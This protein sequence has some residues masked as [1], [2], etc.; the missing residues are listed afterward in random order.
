MPHCI[1]NVRPAEAPA[2][3]F[4]DGL[5]ELGI[6]ILT[7]PNNGT[8]AGGMLIPNSLNPDN[9]TRSYARLDYVDRF[10][11]RPNLHIATHQ[12]VTRVLIDAPHNVKGRDHPDGLWISGVE[13]FILIH[14]YVENVELK[15]PS[16]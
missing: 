12:H 6:P 11:N 7:D 1:D 14:I 15:N 10:V 13:V 4:L 5:Q 2:E 16:L 8:A 9:Q 3:L